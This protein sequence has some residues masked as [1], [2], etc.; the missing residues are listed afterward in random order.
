ML[1]LLLA[2][3]ASPE[4]SSELPF[5]PLVSGPWSVG[6]SQHSLVDEVRERSLP[7]LLWYPTEQAAQAHP[8]ADLVTEAG[9]RS[10]YE[11]LLAQAPADCP[12]RELSDAADAPPAPGPWPLVGMSHCHGCTAFSMAAVA[13]LLA[14][15]GYVVVAPEHVG[16][17][18][19]DELEGTGLPLDTDTLDLR[20][21]DL[22]FSLDAAVDG[23]LG[24]EIDPGR[25]GLLGHSFGAVTVGK[26]LQVRQG[27]TSAPSVAMMVGAPAENPLLPGVDIA[28]IEAPLLFELL[29]EDHSVGVPGNTLIASNF[30]EALGPAWLAELADAGHWSPSDLVGLTDG[31]MPGCGSDVRQEGG[32]EFDYLPPAEGRGLTAALALAF[33]AT[34]L[35][36]DERARAWLADPGLSELTVSS[37]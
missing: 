21:G 13:A 27:G 36:G 14:S 28:S 24:V 3:H 11:A 22:G 25:I 5:D 10:S 31:F 2:C 7:V 15:H 34:N 16:N 35:D 6:R 26:L 37:R 12:T 19:F 17:T 4:D 1:L 23:Q 33:M 30:A 32:G 18:L 8:I 29:A 20:V 9:D